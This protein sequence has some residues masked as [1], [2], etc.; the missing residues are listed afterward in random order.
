MMVN[1]MQ[2]RIEQVRIVE[3]EILDVLHRICDKNGLHYTLFYGTLLGA[4]RHGGFIPWDDDID[5]LMP[6]ED[7][8]RFASVWRE[9]APKG[10]CLLEEKCTMDYTNNFMKVVKDQTTFL[11]RE[12]DR[13]KKFHKG[14][15][16]DIFPCDRVAPAG[17]R[18]RLQ[19]CACAV[20][21]LYT[22]GYTSGTKGLIGM[23][24]RIL[25]LVP[26]KY[27]ATLRN[28]VEPIVVK[29][30]GNARLPMMCPCT[31][32]GCRTYF[33]RDMFEQMDRIGFNGKR[34]GCI[35]EPERMLTICY[36]N[37]ME[38]PPE[39]DRVWKHHPILIDLEHNYEELTSR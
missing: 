26:R 38:L 34:Y 19:Y 4:V 13:E 33:P 28:I 39:E 25:L 30:D 7:Y 5:I 3:Q 20:N 2:E 1:E 18:R 31:I 14:I 36:G 22:R 15:F 6:R 8:E 16:V 9:E 12:D 11:Q 23:I 29:W 24:E 35:R 32:K 21:L 10:Y 27:H 37:Y 17:I